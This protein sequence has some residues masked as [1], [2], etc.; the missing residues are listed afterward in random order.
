MELTCL[1]YTI[2]IGSIYSKSPLNAVSERQKAEC[3]E[4]SED[5]SDFGFVSL[6][7]LRIA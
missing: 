1:Q 5:S 4:K 2:P 3:V 6:Y 7:I